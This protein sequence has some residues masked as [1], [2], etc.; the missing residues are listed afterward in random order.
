MRAWVVVSSALTWAS[1]RVGRCGWVVEWLPIGYER[2]ISVVA[3]G[4]L[5][6]HWPVRKNVAAT[7]LARRV[8]RILGTPSALAPASKVSAT[9]FLVVGRRVHCVP[10]RLA[11]SEV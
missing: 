11:G 7:P 8:A 3:A 10:A 1:G 2:P 4:K 9:T 6:T 5:C